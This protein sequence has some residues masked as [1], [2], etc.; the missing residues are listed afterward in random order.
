MSGRNRDLLAVAAVFGA[1]SLTVAY[2][3]W[4]APYDPPLE[5][6]GQKNLKILGY[7]NGNVDGHSGVITKKANR[8]F[9]FDAIKGTHGDKAKERAENHRWS[10]NMSEKGPNLCSKSVLVMAEAVENKLN[11]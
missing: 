8:E 6:I 2:F 7:Y 10:K 5:T 4:N 11:T 9:L 3:K 1:L